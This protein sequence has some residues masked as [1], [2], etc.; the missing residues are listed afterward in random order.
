MKP[1]KDRTKLNAVWLP[2]DVMRD[3]HHEPE[4]T[5]SRVIHYDDGSAEV[6]ENCICDRLRACE[7]RVT[8][9]WESLRGWG[10]SYAYKTGSDNGF[11]I[12]YAAGVQAA[13]EAVRLSPSAD[14]EVV[15]RSQVIDAIESLGGKQ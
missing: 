2:A 11:L 13:V 1:T 14:I 9:Q 10:E 5:Y 8:E 3:K 6:D 12:G 4:C 15:E 7:Q